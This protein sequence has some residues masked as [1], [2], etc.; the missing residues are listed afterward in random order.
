MVKLSK[1]LV[2]DASVA[3]SAGGAEA[4]YP[5]SVYCRDFLQ[6]V[7]DICHQIAMTPELRDEWNQHQSRFAA[8]W[9]LSMVARKKFCW[10]EPPDRTELWQKIEATAESDG[11]IAAMFKDLHLIQAALTTDQRIASLDDQARTHFRNVASLVV[12]LAGI[13]WINPSQPE[14]AAIAWLKQGAPKGD[15]CL[16]A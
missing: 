4:T 16:A 2:I 10:V 5:T 7:L 8:K 13:A 12:E 9:R 1:T 6:A 3:R 14:E 11:A 15:R